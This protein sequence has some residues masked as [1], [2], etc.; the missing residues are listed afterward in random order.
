MDLQVCGWLCLRTCGGW[1]HGLWVHWSVGLWILMFRKM[2]AESSPLVAASV[3]EKTILISVSLLYL[4]STYYVPTPVL[5]TGR[6]CSE[7]KGIDKI[8][9]L[10]ASVPMGGAWGH[11]CARC[12]AGMWPQGWVPFLLSEGRRRLCLTWGCGP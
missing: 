11:P 10:G 7:Q 5:V 3:R 4:L 8:C 2:W 6:H 12:H 1:F 9:P